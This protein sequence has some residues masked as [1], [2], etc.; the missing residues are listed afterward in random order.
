M[1]Y[2][3]HTSYVKFWKPTTSFTVLA[4]VPLRFCTD[5]EK[6]RHPLSAEDTVLLVLETA[7]VCLLSGKILRDFRSWIITRSKPIKRRIIEAISI[8]ALCSE[9]KNSGCKSSICP[10]FKLLA[11]SSRFVRVWILPRR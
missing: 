8:K 3:L 1:F 2:F 5:Y 7:F 10:S 9:G 6:E 11:L 4:V